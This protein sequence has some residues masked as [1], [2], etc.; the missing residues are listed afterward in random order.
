MSPDST[1]VGCQLLV[2]GRKIRN[3]PV[4]LKGETGHPLSLQLVPDPLESFVFARKTLFHGNT[5][6]SG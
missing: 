1:R 5:S 6:F 3:L 2:P 4:R